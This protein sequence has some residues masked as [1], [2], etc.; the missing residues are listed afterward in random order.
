MTTASA[1]TA[2]H[3]TPHTRTHSPAQ[4]HYSLPVFWPLELMTALG[5]EGFKTVMRGF[6]TATEA[7]KL[8]VGLEAKFATPNRILLEL[9]TMRLRDFSV[10]G[11]TSTE[12]PTLIDA[13]F[14]GHPS[15]IADYTKGQSLVETMMANGLRRVYVTDWR[16]AT[17]DMK[18]Y[19]IDHYLA[20]LNVVVDELGGQVNLVGLC[21]GGW[22]V[23]MY[24]ARYPAKVRS[25]VL[26][27][28]P[29]DTN[30]GHGPI[31]EM[32]HKMKMSDFQRL[33]RL[34]GGLMLGRFML[35]AWKNMHPEQHYFRKY[36]DLFENINDPA[37][38]HKEEAFEAWYENPI[39]LPGRWYLQAVEQLFKENRLAKGTFVG[40]GKRL[41]LGDIHCPVTLLAGESDDITTKERVFDADKYL[42]TPASDIVKLLV[43]GGHIGLFMGSHTLRDTWPGIAQ[44]IARVSA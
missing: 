5:Q 7:L 18:D 44:W 4:A 28:S 33:V 41:S 20:E 25:L 35:A 27:G 12:I 16:S 11:E 29:I 38:V 9:N 39:N 40:L 19:N 26:A 13:P 2:E 34:G 17:L 6:D 37:Y 31:R 1:A 14:A 3:G 15:T 30:A 42:G 43:P 22:M 36:V 8:N 10:E 24:A 21:Q 23:A 32:A